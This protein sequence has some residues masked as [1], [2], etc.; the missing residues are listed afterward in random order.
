ML[1]LRVC[2]NSDWGENVSFEK[3]PTEHQ[4][5]R[6]LSGEL[7]KI[8][9]QSL[10]QASRAQVSAGTKAVTYTLWRGWFYQAPGGSR[11]A[12]KADTLTPD[13]LQPQI[14]AFLSPVGKTLFLG[15]DLL[16]NL[17]PTT[18]NPPKGNL[19][20][21]NMFPDGPCIR[22]GGLWRLSACQNSLDS[23]WNA[24]EQ[25]F[26]QAALSVT[27]VPVQSFSPNE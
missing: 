18:K 13:K 15:K 23:R 17:M 9:L 11:R 24:S 5:L 4:C 6:G 3:I 20:K 25:W 22:F 26:C 16:A 19:H 2:F 12:V 27:V 14:S 8:S 10:P 1:H 7:G 21:G